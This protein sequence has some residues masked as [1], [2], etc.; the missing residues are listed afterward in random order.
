[1]S[2]IS[3]VIQAHLNRNAVVDTEEHRE[4]N[5]SMAH[6][7]LG[8][9]HEAVKEIIDMIRQLPEDVDLEPWVVS[10]ITLAEDYVDTV[11]DYLKQRIG[12]ESESEES[13]QEG[14]GKSSAR[15]VKAYMDHIE[16]GTT[17]Y[18]ESC[19]QMG[20]NYDPKRAR[21]EAKAFI[22]QLIR[23]HGQPPNGAFFRITSNPH[24]F[25]SYLAVVIQFND[26]D[27]KATDYAFKLEN[28]GPENWDAEAKS[29][30]DKE[31]AKL[32][33]DKSAGWEVVPSIDHVKFPNRESEGLEGPFRLRSGLVVYYDPKEGK[34]YNPLTDMFLSHADA[35]A[36]DKRASLKKVD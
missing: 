5:V 28:Q 15:S 35:E 1:V 23:V 30:L 19:E 4:E 14:H 29:E 21:I 13:E 6:G 9:A 26:A 27:E 7:T 11:R 33:Q 2:Q 18:A 16:L 12:G 36:H 24:D 8:N 20:P 31:F 22:N 10:K 17:P 3:R 32:G 25:G 34:Y